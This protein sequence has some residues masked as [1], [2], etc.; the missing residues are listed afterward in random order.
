MPPH[1][2]V[3][4]LGSDG[5]VFPVLSI[6]AELVKRGYDATLLAACVYKEDA[7]RAGLTFVPLSDHDTYNLRLRDTYLLTTRYSS[8]FLRR[9]AIQWNEVIYRSIKRSEATEKIVLA[10][11][12]PCLWA[13]KWLYQTDQIQTIRIQIEPPPPS[14]CRGPKTITPFGQTQVSL[15]AEVQRRFVESAQRCDVDIALHKSSEIEEFPRIGLWSEWFVGGH[16]TNVAADVCGFIMPPAPVRAVCKNDIGNDKNLVVFVAGSRGTTREW[17][18]K[19]FTV[20]ARLCRLLACR[21]VFLGGENPSLKEKECCWLPSA[22]MRPLLSS[23]CAI[24]HHGGIGTA[25]CALETSTPQLVIPRAYGQFEIAE[26]LGRL[27]VAKVLESREYQSRGE[28]ALKSVI[29]NPIYR[30]NSE[31]FSRRIDSAGA[32]NNACELIERRVS[33][34]KKTTAPPVAARD[35]LY[36]I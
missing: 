1:Y 34:W 15:A 22:A 14:Q 32:L 31:D 20:S 18:Q 26:W 33:E 36:R 35:G 24:V 12:H 16:S 6:G 27:R 9:Y 30:R 17:S 5:D 8:L 29:T 19:F 4:S 23:A 7:A 11:E 3:V 21:G 28:A 10:V 2:F 13:H 25:L